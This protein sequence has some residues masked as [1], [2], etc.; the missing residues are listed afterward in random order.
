MALKKRIPLFESN[1]KDKSIK[2]E[3]S[4]YIKNG[5]SDAYIEAK[6]WGKWKGQYSIGDVSEMIKELKS[7]K[8]KLVESKDGKIDQKYLTKLY[9][10]HAG[11]MPENGDF[12]EQY[13]FVNGVWVKNPK[14]N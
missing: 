5:L 2:D 12:F 8:L 4:E 11:K 7:N 10:E 6:I 1:N 14:F 13:D 3:I 9:F